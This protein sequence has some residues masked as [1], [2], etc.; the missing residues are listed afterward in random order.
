MPRPIAQQARGVRQPETFAGFLRIGGIHEAL[1]HL[2]GGAETHVRKAL[3]AKFALTP[4]PPAIVRRKQLTQHSLGMLTGPC[5]GSLLF[6]E[7]IRNA[8]R[9]QIG[10]REVDVGVSNQI[11]PTN[12]TF[13]G[14]PCRGPGREPFGRQDEAR[15]YF[16]D[17][18]AF[19][20]VVNI[21]PPSKP[22]EFEGK[23]VPQHGLEALASKNPNSLASLTRNKRCPL[24]FCPRFTVDRKQLIVCV[25]RL[26][27]A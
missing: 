6:L 8:F 22:P 11:K 12:A 21:P 5:D 1:R 25:L 3:C 10:A 23:L 26:A 19:T 14:D 4:T 20:A 16:H 24:P 13:R 7:R 27:P 9:M 17:F 2:V 15:L 18:Y